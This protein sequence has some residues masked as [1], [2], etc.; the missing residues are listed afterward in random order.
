MTLKERTNHWSEGASTAAS[1]N[2][3]VI[4]LIFT[5]LTLVSAGREIGPKR[6]K[7]R[8]SAATMRGD[9]SD[10]VVCQNT[11]TSRYYKAYACAI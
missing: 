5:G 4:T 2:T 9:Q 8:K 1:H 10:T 7:K 3:K 6:E 11:T